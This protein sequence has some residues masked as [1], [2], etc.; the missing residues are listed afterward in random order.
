MPRVIQTTRQD[1]LVAQGRQAAP[2][3]GSCDRRRRLFH[4]ASGIGAGR[5]RSPD[6]G[7]SHRTVPGP[8]VHGPSTAPHTRTGPISSV[9]RL[10]RPRRPCS[11]GCSGAPRGYRNDRLR[12]PAAQRRSFAPGASRR[13]SHGHRTRRPSPGRPAR[14]RR[15]ERYTNVS[16]SCPPSGRAAG[17]ATSVGG[18]TRMPPGPPKSAAWE[19]LRSM[20][21][22]GSIQ[23]RE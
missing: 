10:T 15:P 1:A 18:V 8:C 13:S 22:S 23:R 19:H 6:R 16:R 20:A 3:P 14:A 11:D 21:D 5:R 7:C 4:A 9:K 2:F 12:L 17:Q